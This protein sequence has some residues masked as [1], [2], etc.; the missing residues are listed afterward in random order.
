MACS[1][2]HSASPS[3][4]SRSSPLSDGTDR[5]SPKSISTTP[6]E[7]DTSFL[8]S[9][10]P[11]EVAALLPQDSSSIDRLHTASAVDSSKSR[12]THRHISPED[13]AHGVYYKAPIL[14]VLSSLLGV[15]ASLGHHFLYS[16]FDGA[17]VESNWEQE[18]NIRSSC[19]L[20]STTR[21]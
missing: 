11:L 7:K 20:D 5:L 18:W 9:P 2:S 3:A 6:S 1:G 13:Q 8:V 17:V 19:R 15:S 4:L 12:I 21:S 10:E 16:H 14:M